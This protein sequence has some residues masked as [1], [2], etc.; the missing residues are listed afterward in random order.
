MQVKPFPA[1]SATQTE[2]VVDM[3]HYLLEG[4]GWSIGAALSGKYGHEHGVLFEIALKANNLRVLY[5]PG[6]RTAMAIA[7]VIKLRSEE[8]RLP[9]GLWTGVVDRV[10]NKAP[11]RDVIEALS[12]MNNDV[13]SY[14]SK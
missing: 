5:A 6:D 7:S 14:L 2:N 10:R 4:D 9:P 13:L 3:L 11:H 1:R 12:K 8:I